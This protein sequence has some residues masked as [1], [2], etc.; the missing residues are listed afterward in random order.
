MILTTAGF[1]TTFGFIAWIAGMALE[2][3][4]VAVIGGVIVVGVGASIMD[5]GLQYRDGETQVVNETA[6]TTTIEPTYSSVPLPQHLSLGALVTLLG[7][8]LTLQ[9]INRFGES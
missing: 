5:S 2:Y 6:N 8:L 1:I 4:G 7:G 9:G 3:P